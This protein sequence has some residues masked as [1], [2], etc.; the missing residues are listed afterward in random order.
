ML[1]SSHLIV[2]KTERFINDKITTTK[3]DL[4]TNSRLGEI[5]KRDYSF[6]L[7]NKT[8]LHLAPGNNAEIAYQLFE[9]PINKYIANGI[10]GPNI[11]KGF[12]LEEPRKEGKIQICNLGYLAALDLAQKEGETIVL[13]EKDI[14]EKFYKKQELIEKIYA[15][16]PPK[17]L[18]I[19]PNRSEKSTE[20]ILENGFN[21]EGLYGFKKQD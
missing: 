4:K 3:M 1:F 5:I 16:T 13:S 7:V 6:E 11:T 8:I 9:I 18:L 12:N 2:T 15:I 14:I 17:G 21:E 10:V 19:L 20:L